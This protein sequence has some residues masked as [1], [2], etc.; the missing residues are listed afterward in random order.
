M[1]KHIIGQAIYQLVIVLVV[2][3][4]GQNFLYENN[5]YNSKLVF[6][7]N[8]CFNAGIVVSPSNTTLANYDAVKPTVYVVSGLGTL[9]TNSTK[10][11]TFPDVKGC[12]AFLAN[13][14]ITN[15]QTV[16]QSNAYDSLVI[17]I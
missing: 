13:I 10:N 11:F 9:F 1:F 2:L 7:F 3:F 6:A 16:S 8:Y 5:A 12:N 14:S 4:Y 15:N 17:V